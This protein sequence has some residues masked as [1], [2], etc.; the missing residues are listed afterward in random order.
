MIAIDPTLATPLV[1]QVYDALLR[2]ISSSAMKPGDR[3]PSVR[4][5]AAACGVSTMTVTNAYQRLVAE[6]HVEARSASG[7]YVAAAERSGTR[8]KPF[9]GRTSV[10]SLWLLKHVYEDDRSLL[11]AGCGWVPPELLHTEG[12]RRALAALSRKSAAGLANYGN[13][14]GYLPLRQQIQVLLAQKGIEAPPHQIVLTHGASQALILAAR[15]LL[16]PHD[17]VLV[18]EPSSTNLFAMLRS[19]DLKLVGIER[20]TQGPDLEALRTLAQRHRAKA[21]FTTANLHNPTGSQCSPAVAYQLLRLAEQLDFHIVDNDTMSGLEPPG[22]TSLASLD[23]LQRVI[24]IGSFSKTVSPSLRVG[25]VA[26]SEEFA[27]KLIL[28]KMVNSLTTSELNEKLLHGVLA[29]GRFRTHLTRL[30]EQLR[31]AQE[32]VCDGLEAAGM[33]LFLRPAGGP[34]L[35]ARFERDDVDM[36]ALAQRAIAEGFL[37]APGDLFRTDLRPTPWLRFNVGYAD[38]ARLYRYLAAEGG[39]SRLKRSAAR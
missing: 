20:T 31:A 5:L 15:C 38:D 12:V 16:Q 9:A 27:E 39:R 37:L 1:R 19:L 14:Y 24:H 21:F 29:E 8:R 4:G 33:Q 32:K 25:F 3:L 13:P 17:V 30:A 23:R 28:H 18:D 26:C 10:D 34:F 36:R 35:W 2:D 7:Y 11:N 22:A 6:G